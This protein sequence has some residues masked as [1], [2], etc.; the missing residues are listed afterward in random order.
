MKKTVTIHPQQTIGTPD[1]RMW[2]IFYEEINHAG[3][4]GIYAEL[5][6]NRSFADARLPE[7]TT[8]AGGKVHT[9]LGHIEDF[10]VSDPLPGWKLL[11]TPGMAASMQLTRENPR[12][13]ACAEQLELDVLRPAGGVRVVNEGYCGIPVKE[14]DYYGY[15]IA[16]GE[17]ITHVTVG[18]MYSGGV[19]ICETQLSLTEEFQK[20]PFR[21]AS[22]VR[23]PDARFFLQADEAGSLYVDFATLFPQDTDLGRPYGFRRDLMD[24]LRGLR[25]GFLRFPG[26]CV[27]EGINL[28]NA[29]HWKQTRGPMEDRPGHW[30]LWG[31]RAT[32]GLG[33]LEFCE[34][35]E[36]LGADLMYVVNCGMSCQARKSVPG[37][38]EEIQWWLQNALDGIEYI[39]GDASTEY[40]ALRAADGHPEP[41]RLKYVEIGN[42]NWGP[43]YHKRYRIFY[44]AIKAKYPDLI[45]IANERVPDAPLDMVDDHHYTSPQT[46]PNRWGVYEG[47]GTPV[48]IGEYAC[49]GESGHGN[50]IGAV[51]EAVFMIRIENRC[52]RVRIASYAPLFCNEDYRKWSVNLINF[53]GT[54]TYGIPSYEVQRLFAEYAPET[55]VAADCEVNPG[56][57]ANLY[58]TAGKK[59]GALVVKAANYG[60]EP[61]EALFTAEGGSFIPSG[62]VLIASGSP[63]DT[64]D[65][66]TPGRVKAVP[67]PVKQQAGGA[68]FT[69]PPYSF[70][71]L[72]G[73]V[74]P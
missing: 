6:R 44:D 61:I 5:L 55:V 51:S 4:G 35:G 63:T 17:G 52:D 24:M 23:T 12:N 2:G 45:L 36:D 53:N 22:P 9:R 50:L 21:F 42:E 34:L 46:F 20:L 47:E 13:P 68:S 38:D 40:G 30:D 16:R 49:N 39:C 56:A 64:N 14:Q 15:V 58:V 60:D 41:F 8:Y 69:L 1:P 43:E 28:E 57:N 71:V 3:D 59:D 19:V 48:Y 10:D 72:T 66:V 62:A 33:M 11:P 70:A 73:R 31:Y 32:D 26:G 25:P 54:G 74:E 65:L 7:N 27:V 67:A 18:L 37:T 29:I